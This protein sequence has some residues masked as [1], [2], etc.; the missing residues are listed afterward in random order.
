MRFI[1]ALLL[2]ACGVLAA[3]S[4][5][6]ARRPDAKRFIDKMVPYE[7]VLGVVLFACGVLLLLRNVFD[8]PGV[9][10]IGL[11]RGITWCAYIGSALLLGFLF[12]LPVIA[13][14]IPGESPAEVKAFEMQKKVAVYQT[15]IGLVAIVSG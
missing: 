7:G 2:I 15:G 9:F 8:L 12:G 13:K 5:I 4:F 3:S 6:I 11:F 14:W 10:R 1:V